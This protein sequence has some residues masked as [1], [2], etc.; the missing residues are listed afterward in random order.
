MEK[1]GGYQPLSRQGAHMKEEMLV[2]GYVVEAG[3]IEVTSMNGAAEKHENS[4]L[5]RF[6]T[7]EDFRKAI[8]D[9]LI[10]LTLFPDPSEL[11]T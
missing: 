4:F 2:L 11:E 3:D 10:V 9:R 6:K 7:T 1:Q 8:V 5:V